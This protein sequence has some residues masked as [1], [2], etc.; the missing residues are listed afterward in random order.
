MNQEKITKV[1]QILALTDQEIEELTDET[2]KRLSYGIKY[3]S[4]NFYSGDLQRAARILRGLGVRLDNMK[5]PPYHTDDELRAM[6]ARVRA[7]ERIDDME[8]EF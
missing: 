4:L 5:R 3:Y 8:P 7:Q 6:R 1:G 2:I